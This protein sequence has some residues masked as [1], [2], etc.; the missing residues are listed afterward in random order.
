M[1]TRSFAAATLI[2]VTM[3]AVVRAEP[4]S[5]TSP[6]GKIEVTLQLNDRGQPTFDVKRSG[7][8]VASG[9]LGL[10]FAER[11]ALA[12]RL[13]VIGQ[14]TS[15]RDET[16]AIAVGKT[17]SARDHHNELIVALAESQPPQRKVEV[18]V[19]V[20]DDGVAF[21][22]QLPEQAAIT[23]FVITDELTR[24]SVPPQTPAKLL[25]LKNYTT[26]YEW[27]YDDKVVS[28]IDPKQL[29]GVPI[30]LQPPGGNWLAITEADLTDYA[31]MYLSRDANDVGT[32]VAKLSPLPG[33]NDR[34][35][36]IGNAP[37]NSPWRVLMIGD[38][39]AALLESNIVFNLN[40]PSKIADTSTLR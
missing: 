12:E 10:E 13:T 6:D 29:I 23:D 16:Y 11:G 27:Y 38:S 4:L 17:S 35:K 2:A 32:F 22:Y 9:S 8:P 36:V 1:P 7:A 15:S 18:A 19:R 31:G 5:L 40:Q 20:F 33:R 24:I 3:S 21:R 30:L 39:P 37:F 26:P 34:A 28:A 25:P 14:R